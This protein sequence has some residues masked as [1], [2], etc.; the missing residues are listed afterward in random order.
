[1]SEVIPSINVFEAF[2]PEC[3]VVQNAEGKSG[4][5]IGT[6]QMIEGS[7]PTVML[8]MS[9]NRWQQAQTQ[10]HTVPSISI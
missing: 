8:L 4:L 6:L 5:C 9:K 1:M 7:E 3:T 2:I 10:I